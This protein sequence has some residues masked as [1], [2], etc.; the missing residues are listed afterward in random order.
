MSIS[1]IAASYKQE[2]LTTTVTPEHISFS[3]RATPQLKTLHITSAKATT[4]NDFQTL[5]RTTAQES[6]N[7]MP[8]KNSKPESKSNILSTVGLFHSETVTISTVSSTHNDISIRGTLLSDDN[9]TQ[10]TPIA[11]STSESPNASTGTFETASNVAI[12]STVA[13]SVALLTAVLLIYSY[14]SQT[15]CT[16]Q[17]YNRY[18]FISVV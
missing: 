13:T 5:F 4:I 12:V 17:L 18:V 10:A 3:T 16:G 8:S 15:A 11:L 6:T 7:R 1:T 2:Q 9:E 14:M